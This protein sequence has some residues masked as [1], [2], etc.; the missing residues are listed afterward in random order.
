MDRFLV[1]E[2]FENAAEVQAG[3]NACCKGNGT[4]GLANQFIQKP[5]AALGIRKT[6]AGSVV[7]FMRWRV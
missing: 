3:A 1:I 5:G 4:P 2:A 6:G 7:N